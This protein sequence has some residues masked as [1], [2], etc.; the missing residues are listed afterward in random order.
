[1]GILNVT[2]DSFSDGGKYTTADS[3]LAHA[4]DMISHGADIIDVGGE[5]TRPGSGGVSPQ[6]EIDRVIPVIRAIRKQSG[7]AIS[8]DTSKAAVIRAAKSE[9]IDLINDVRALRGEG[10]M[11]EV[12]KS[13]LPICLMHM[14]GE[15]KTMQENPIYTDVVEEVYQFLRE[16]VRV[17]YQ[18]GIEPSRLILDIGFGFGKSLKDNLVLVNRLSTFLDLGLPLL[19]GMSRKSTITKIA[20]DPIIGSISAALF[21][22]NKGATILRVH[23][24]AQTRSAIEVWQSFKEERYINVDV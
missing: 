3:A 2:P 9:D 16:R 19:V 23:D 1:M 6:E 22:I 7:V 10:V 17:C 13:D 18:A 5:S 15:P 8:L 12:T 4:L 11:K 14:K 20:Q 24:V 21:A